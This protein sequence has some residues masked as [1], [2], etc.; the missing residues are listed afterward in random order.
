MRIAINGMGRIGRLLAKLLA[1]TDHE[2]VAV[3]DLMSKSNLTYLLKFDSIYGQYFNN[4]V[5]ISEKSDGISINDKLIRILNEARPLQ[6]PWKE[7]DIDLVIDCSG[8]F[9]SFNALRD[10]LQAGARRVLLSTTGTTDVPLLIRGFNDHALSKATPIVA[11]G[12]CM[13]N[14]TVPIIH[15]LEQ[16][17]EIE[18]LHINVLH[19]YTSRQ[20]LVDG[21]HS[22]FRRGR[23]AASSIIPVAVDLAQNLKRIFETLDQKIEATSTRIPI[24]CG[25]LVDMHAVLRKSPN[26]NEVHELF[27]GL[28]GTDLKG[29]LQVN[30]DPIV[31]RDII[32][33]AHSAIIDSTLTRAIGN[34]LKL[35]AWFDD[36]FAFTTRLVEIANRMSE[37]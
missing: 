33:N 31:S 30:E 28:S 11:S 6:L 21:E 8:K 20:S 35:C 18:S 15:Y 23:A 10:H 25:A 19:S 36:Q 12:G 7:L 24:E 27:K 4:K 16:H 29:I 26:V 22:D 14:C 17:Y 32:C 5:E 37:R 3:N 1:T 9:L 13:V 34:H 2:I